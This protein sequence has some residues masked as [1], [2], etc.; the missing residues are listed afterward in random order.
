MRQSKGPF[1][2]VT[3]RGGAIALFVASLPLIPGW[4]VSLG[5]RASKLPWGSE[6]WG[7]FC[8][9]GMRVPI[10]RLEMGSQTSCQW[11][12][13]HFFHSCGRGRKRL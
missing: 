11:A 10:R 8:S 9:P 4:Q 12:L 2:R 3:E 13:C 7:A 1:L 5:A 6:H